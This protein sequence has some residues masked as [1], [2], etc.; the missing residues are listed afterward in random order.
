MLENGPP[1]N[2]DG[3]NG[4]MA[5]WSARS[6]A[7]RSPWRELLVLV[8]PEELVQPTTLDDFVQQDRKRNK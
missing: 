1:E 2:D 4:F 8:E 3:Q 5:P 7:L 6:R